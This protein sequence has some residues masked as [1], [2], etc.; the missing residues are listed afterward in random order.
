MT[1]P[2]DPTSA[3][4]GP[5]RV[6]EDEQHFIVQIHPE[7]RDRA[8]KILGRQWDGVRKAW[9]Y[10]K[11]PASYDALTQEFQRDAAK[12]DIRRPKTK[13]PPTLSIGVSAAATEV[14]EWEI[15]DEQVSHHPKLQVEIDGI[16]ESL[17]K[18]GDL[19]LGQSRSL[20]EMQTSQQHISDSLGQLNSAKTS[21]PTP[22][23]TEP[24]PDVL[25]LNKSSELRV[26]E[27]TLIHLA[28]CTAG[29]SKSLFEWLGKHRPLDRPRDFVTASHNLLNQQLEKIVGVPSQELSFADLVGK[30]QMDNLIYNE[31]FDPVQV[32][33]TLR[34]MNAYRN[35]LIHASSLSVSESLSRAVLYL[36]NLAFV[37]PRIM[38][39]D[40]DE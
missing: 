25:S 11:T 36:I 5:V 13:R 34:A 37:W 14:Q 18:L 35:T 4:F 27:T 15:P 30:A 20:D 6:T 2:I 12:F 39:D 21:N 40:D 26:L 29:N 24:L 38:M 16:R 17:A 7:Q 10:R 22:P 32:I 31:R 8:K 1:L 28:F 9:I 3:N 23:P 19:F 33:P